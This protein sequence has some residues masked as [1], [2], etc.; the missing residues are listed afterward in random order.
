MLITDHDLKLYFCA[1]ILN[2]N[3]NTL[4]RNPLKPN[5]N[6][7]SGN[8]HFTAIGPVFHECENMQSHIPVRNQMA[9]LERRMADWFS[10]NSFEFIGTH[11]KLRDD[12]Y[13]IIDSS[14]SAD[15]HFRRQQGKDTNVV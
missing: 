13:Q 1:T 15:F 7:E 10:D 11:P 3:S 14:V 5:V 6:P 2:Y 8:F 4:I 12:V 9:A